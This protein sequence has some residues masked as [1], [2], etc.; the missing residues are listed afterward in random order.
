MIRDEIN[1][2]IKEELQ[3]FVN[4]YAN[5][6]DKAKPHLIK[7]YSEGIVDMLLGMG[8]IN[9]IEACDCVYTRSIDANGDQIIIPCEKHK[10]D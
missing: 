6:S 5:A 4:S 2:H 1:D 9:L 3:S 10:N 8:V 7:S